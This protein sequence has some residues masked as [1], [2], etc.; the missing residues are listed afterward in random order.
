MKLTS[1]RSALFSAAMIPAVALCR[2]ARTVGADVVLLALGERFDALAAQID[3]G[4]E[5]G[6]DITWKTLEEFGCIN[7]AI[8]ATPATTMQGLYVK[9]RAGCWALLGDF[10]SADQSASGARMAF[11]MMR[12]LIRLH[13]SHLENTGAA[14]VN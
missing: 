3:H 4:I 14:E 9:A 5:H 13:A 11:S 8:V 6:L 1:L 7:A 2:Q 12:D 10:D